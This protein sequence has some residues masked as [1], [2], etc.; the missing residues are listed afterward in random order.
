LVKWLQ[1][2]RFTPKKTLFISN[3]ARVPNAM[4]VWLQKHKAYKNAKFCIILPKKSALDAKDFPTEGIF[5]LALD[6]DART[7]TSIV[8]KA[9]AALSA[10]KKC[11]IGLVGA[12]N[13]QGKTAVKEELDEAEKAGLCAAIVDTTYF[14][15]KE[16]EA[17]SSDQCISMNR[18]KHIDRVDPHKDPARHKLLTVRTQQER[19]VELT[20]WLM[21]QSRL[22]LDYEGGTQVEF[23]SPPN[24]KEVKKIKSNVMKLISLALKSSLTFCDSVRAEK[25]KEKEKNMKDTVNQLVSKKRTVLAR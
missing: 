25:R 19:K 23:K 3:G 11:V 16:I 6:V 12:K 9:M 15:D 18:K 24:S 10:H 8:T 7:R 14:D 5:D 13:A 1:D 21:S 22:Y 2:R 4:L 17:Y 20:T